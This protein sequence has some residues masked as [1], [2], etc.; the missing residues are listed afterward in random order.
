MTRRPGVL[1]N[2][3]LLLLTAAI[4][5]FAFVA[6]R[7]GMEYVGPF[8]YTAVRFALG[9]IALLPLV[10]VERRAARRAPVAHAAVAAAVAAPSPVSG[11][12]SVVRPISPLAGGLL[13]GVVLFGGAILQQ[14]GL[15]WTTAGKAGFVTGL[16]VVLVP[17]AGLLWGQHPGWSRWLG[18]AL[19]AA[20]LFLLGVTRSFTLERG[21]MLVLV[22][23]LFWTA[24]VHVVGWL[25]PRT[26][27]VALSCVQFAV[28]SV[29]SGIVMP[30]TE[31]VTVEALQTA[32]VPILYGG[33]V[34]V[35]VA[36]TLQVVAQRHAPPAHAAI[37][38]SLETV[39]AA[40]GGW[41]V[42]GE[43]LSPR[44]IAGCCLMLAGMLCSQLPVLL[45]RRHLPEAPPS[46]P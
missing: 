3:A 42:L 40:L 28:C 18:A 32:A 39:F 41:I 22:G 12:A 33:L 21:D 5:G 1:A 20:G 25:S 30:F 19:A 11:T 35:G 16:Y 23:A 7:A 9:S 31:R 38:L 43:R 36:Y 34:S 26:R 13:A 2:D 27:P 46:S 4:W 8:A 24:H 10:F 6:Q 37:L 15:V 17:L 45:P 29:L 44:S 14:A